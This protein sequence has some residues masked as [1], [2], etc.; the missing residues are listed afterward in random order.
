MSN[1]VFVN[2][3]LLVQQSQKE[4]GVNGVTE[5]SITVSISLHRYVTS[6][7]LYVVYLLIVMYV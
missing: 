5:K 1:I 7:T 6:T 2:F 3:Q 4:D